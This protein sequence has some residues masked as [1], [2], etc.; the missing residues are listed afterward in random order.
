MSL[1]SVNNGA[2]NNKHNGQII[3]TDQTKNN[4]NNTVQLIGHENT[5]LSVS[6]DPNGEFLASSGADKRVILWDTITN[7]NV[8]ECIGHKGAVTSLDFSFDG[9]TLYSSS[10]D[11]TLGTWD[12][13]RC[14]RLIKHVGHEDM[15]NDLA[16][17][18]KGGEKLVSGSDDGSI[19]IW[20]PGEAKQAVMYWYTEYP[21]LSVTC[22]AIGQMIWTTGIESDIKAWDVRK[23]NEPVYTLPG[24]NQETI[25]SL[26]IDSKGETMASFGQD[27]A[28]RTWDIKPFVKEEG[29][30]GN[31]SNRALK[32]YD[33][34]VHS[35]E[36]NL[37]RVVFSSGEGDSRTRM[38]AASADGTV[39]V[40][41]VNTRSLQK[42][43]GH[44][45]SVNDV[46]ISSTGWLASGSTDRT[47]LLRKL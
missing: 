33:G 10:T 7:Q 12:A 32:V 24:H 2:N 15:I 38:A 5:I 8:G 6:F 36:Q 17:I 20:S 44:K 22:D 31:N 23:S 34:A 28:V 27:N 13:E 42:L 1:I 9:L 45:G 40:W 39:A 18:R 37:H 46:S 4:K 35:M 11:L 41:D 25:T 19:A 26:C 29:G 16:V 43:S 14:V 47:V 3:Q 30:E 21:V